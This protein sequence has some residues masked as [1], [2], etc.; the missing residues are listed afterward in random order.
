MKKFQDLYWTHH[1]A[2]YSAILHIQGIVPPNTV[3]IIPPM[4]INDEMGF[5][6]TIPVPDQTIQFKIDHRAMVFMI[7]NFYNQLLS[8]ELRL[9]RESDRK[10]AEDTFSAKL[11]L[12]PS[13]T[14]LPVKLAAV[15]MFSDFLEFIVST[16]LLWDWNGNSKFGVPDRFFSA[17]YTFAKDRAKQSRPTSIPLPT[18][19]DFLS[20]GTP[21]LTRHRLMLA[22]KRFKTET[23]RLQKILSDLGFI[24]PIIYELLGKRLKFQFYSRTPSC[25]S[26][27]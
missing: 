16:L 3:T 10:E 25:L 6:I 26:R 2:A 9:V 14:K 22:F 15:T 21:W 7:G 12:D 4:K 13:P 19:F 1:G 27:W 23:T 11:G 20:P 5:Q 24:Q 17:A 18:M 8:S